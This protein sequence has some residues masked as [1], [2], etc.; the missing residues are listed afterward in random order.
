MKR[1]NVFKMFAAVAVFAIIGVNQAFAQNE[2]YVYKD[3]L[4][5]NVLTSRTILKRDNK[6]ASFTQYM[7][8]DYTYDEFDRI[9]TQCVS[10]WNSSED[11]W[12][13]SLSYTYS[14][15]DGLYSI[16]LSR[17]IQNPYDLVLKRERS[18]YTIDD[19]RN[20]LLSQ[21]Y[22]WDRKNRDWIL[23]NELMIDSVPLLGEII[24]KQ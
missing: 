18:V 10:R 8:K 14:Y 15:E 16:E 6:N 13:K 12:D 9:K 1:N 21:R 4:I 5:N 19:S 17:H 2:N 24:D 20:L 23:I 7:K 11:R 3:E 22:E